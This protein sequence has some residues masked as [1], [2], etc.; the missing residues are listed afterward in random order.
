MATPRAT[1]RYTSSETFG[2]EV[3]P[4]EKTPTRSHSFKV[5]HGS[6]LYPLSEKA[7]CIYCSLHNQISITQRKCPDCPL[8]PALCQTLEKDCHA[9]WHSTTFEKLRNLWYEHVERRQKP[10]E[11][12]ATPP[13]SQRGRPKG[14]INKRRRRGM[15]RTK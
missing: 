9:K 13:P 15:Y 8:S 12:T 10:N 2:R 1:N 5:R 3:S 4:R 14:S 11:Q 7:R 6:Q